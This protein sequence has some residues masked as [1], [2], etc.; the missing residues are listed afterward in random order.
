MVKRVKRDAE[1]ADETDDNAHIYFAIVHVHE[2]VH[3]HLALLILTTDEACNVQHDK[4]YSRPHYRSSKR[5]V[6]SAFPA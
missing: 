3:L 4:H 1:L 6:V 5:Q 2:H